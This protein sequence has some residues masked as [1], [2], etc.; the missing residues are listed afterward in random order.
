MSFGARL[1]WENVAR[2][3][4]IDPQIVAPVQTANPDFYGGESWYGFLSVNVAGQH[5]WRRGHRLA[6][7][8]GVPIEQDLNGPQME[9]DWILTAGWQYSF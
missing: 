8:Y 6:L 7:E 9:T 2:I 5:D 3:D 1:A 4:G